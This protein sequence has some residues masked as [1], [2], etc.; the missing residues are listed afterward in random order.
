MGKRRFNDC[1]GIEENCIYRFAK[2][3]LE[4]T[5]LFREMICARNVNCK[6]LCTT[7]RV[8]WSKCSNPREIG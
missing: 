5:S 8:R 7:D 6:C 2:L 3:L 1:C 4:I